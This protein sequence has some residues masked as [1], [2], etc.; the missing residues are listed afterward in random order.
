MTTNLTIQKGA[1][2]VTIQTIEIS[3]DYSNDFTTLA[4]PITKNNHATGP[5]DNKIMDL[6]RINHT[7]VIRGAL[8]NTTDRNNLI[9]IFKGADVSGQPAKVTYNTHPDTPLSMFPE[10][11]MIKEYSTDNITA[12]QYKYEVQLTLIEGVSM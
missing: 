2:S 3:E 7:I 9:K 6:L 11:L 10:K 12:N 1:Y 8:T 4:I 5:K